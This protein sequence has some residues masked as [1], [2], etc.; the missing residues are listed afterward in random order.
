MKLKTITISIA[1][2]TLGLINVQAQQG[3]LNLS[4]DSAKI[5]ALRYNKTLLK[6]GLSITESQ[7]ELWDAISNG[8][9]QV[10]AIYGYQNFLGA[11]LK[12]DLGIPGMSTFLI[13]MNP[14]S[15]LQVQVSQLIFSGSYWVGIEMSKLAEQI[16]KT[17]YNKTELD[18]CKQVTESY[19]AILVAQET[20]RIV[21]GN[22]ENL[23][24]MKKK[25]EAMAAVGVTEQT[26]AD[27]ISIQVASM[28]NSLKQMDRQIELAYNMLRLQLGVKA[29]L[30]LT[31]TEPLEGFVNEITIADLIEEPFQ[32]NQNNNV[33]LMDQSVEMA[34]K[35]LKM[36][37]TNF[38]PT[39][40]AFY[41]YTYKIQ[42][43][44]F[45]TQ[46]VNV[47]GIN[48]SMPLFTGGGNCSK[49]KQA[50][51]KLEQAELDRQNVIDQM[52][53]QEKQLRFNLKNALESYEIQKKN[54]NVSNRV[55]KSVSQKY[56][57]GVSSSLDLTTASSNLLTAQNNYIS[58]LY[59][60]LSAQTELQNLLGKK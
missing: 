27:Q 2:F 5:Y 37:Y 16:N 47:I 38:M 34:K 31:L 9:P 53:V 14:T 18:V 7:S 3:N 40:A 11:D 36:A 15:N 58:S 25:T 17:S 21:E 55:Y 43:S 52:L 22:I 6:S 54:I 33:I 13:P 56:E 29:S 8:L 46:P 44:D 28:E 12:L 41:D 30:Q 51:I 60:L 1:L 50:K 4:L 57:Q 32:V 26:N 45:D 20:K 42:K 59:Q 19:Y 24:E 10:K 35:Q 23:R 49:V 48:A 39:V